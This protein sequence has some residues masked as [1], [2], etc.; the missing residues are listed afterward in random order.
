MM[1]PCSARTPRLIDFWT[2]IAAHQQKASSSVGAQ[3]LDVLSSPPCCNMNED[4]D[5]ITRQSLRL[6]SITAHSSDADQAVPKVSK[7]VNCYLEEMSIV[8]RQGGWREEDI[9]DMMGAEARLPT[10]WDHQLDAQVKI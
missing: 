7:W 5:I 6:D 9:S 8:L 4:H 10:M 3:V 2:D 1:P